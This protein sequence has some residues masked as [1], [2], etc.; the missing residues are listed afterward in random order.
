MKKFKSIIL[1][2][3]AVACLSTPASAQFK[4]GIQ[5]GIVA[6]DLHFNSDLFDSSNRVGFTGGLTAQYNFIMG[7]G[8]QASLM[9][10]HRTSEAIDKSQNETGIIKGDYLT[11]PIHVKYNFNL[12]AINNLFR[13]FIFTG[14]SFSYLLSKKQ[15]VF[16][17]ATRKGDVAWDLGIGADIINHI[18]LSVGYGFGCTAIAK[19]YN[20]K[21]RQNSWTITLGYL[22]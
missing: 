1:V 9:Y 16:G 7:L 6:N 8:L 22:F 5:A 20:N 15:N 11:L 21:V 2:I 13:P 17:D 10:V 4:W 12:P 14:P 3:L 18:Q 19:E